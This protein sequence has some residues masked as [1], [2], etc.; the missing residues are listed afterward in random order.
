MGNLKISNIQTDA[1]RSAGKT[2]EWKVIDERWDTQL[3]SV[4]G[5]RREISD[6]LGFHSHFCNSKLIITMRKK[7]ALFGDK[8]M[9]PPLGSAYCPTFFP[10]LSLKEVTGKKKKPTNHHKETQPKHLY[11]KATRNNKIKY[12]WL[13]LSKPRDCILYTCDK[14]N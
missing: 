10:P 2:G 11:N 13:K 4:W 6:I 7:I 3:C 9:I 5:R 14:A 8:E 12:V 1:R